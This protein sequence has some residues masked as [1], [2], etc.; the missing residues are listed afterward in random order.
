MRHI[1]VKNVPSC[2]LARD[3]MLLNSH[4]SVQLESGRGHCQAVILEALIQE[5]LILEIYPSYQIVRMKSPHLLKA[6]KPSMHN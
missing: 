3:T 5:I 6:F 4:Q 2:L 1:I